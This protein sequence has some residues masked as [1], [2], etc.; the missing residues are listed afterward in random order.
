[1]E[2]NLIHGEGDLYGKPYRLLPWHREFTWRFYELDPDG[3]PGA[4]WYT[5]ALAGAESGAV[6]TEFF[7]ALAMLEF[8]GP[9]PFR[10]STPIITMMA[11]SYE[12]AKELFGQAQIMAGGTNDAPVVTAPLAGM[13]SVFE[14]VIEYG[15][16]RPGRIQRV[17][18]K[19]ATAEGGKETLLLGDELH[20][21]TGP[22]ERVWTVRAKSLTKR[23]PV[24]GRAVALSTAGVGRGSIPARDTDALLWRMYAR[25]MVERGDPASR[26]LFDWRE[27]PPEIEH[28]RDDPEALRRHLSAMR[29]ADVAW[30]VEVRA[31]EIES[32]KIP[33][34]EALRYYFN[35]FLAYGSDSWQ[36][37]MPGVWEECGAGAE[38]IPADGSEVVVG[39]DMALHGDSVGVIV[40]GRLSDG[41]VGWYPRHWAAVEGRIDH[42]DVFATIAGT[43]AQ[44]WKIRSVTYDPR[45]FELPARML[46]DQGIAAIEFPQS[47]ERLIPADGLVFELAKAHGLAHPDDPVLDA[48]SANCSWRETERG[49]YFSKG[50]SAGHMD[51]MRAGSMATW[52]LLAGEVP[53]EGGPNLW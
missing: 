47:P 53:D 42:A 10:R 33:W 44:R 37:E 27:A 12:Q 43:I 36:A 28:L 40:A 21:L 29:A 8:G 52:E 30:S 14:K 9:A 11:N 41:R 48:H 5:E 35:R 34:R 19:A 1:M 7:A 17:A 6:K 51:L 38:A 2:R 15:D 16:G 13:F 22:K 45:F 20:E 39:V 50:R 49:R 46:E 25:G 24:P 4:W 23:T 32:G 3:G 26:Y 31:R 18:A